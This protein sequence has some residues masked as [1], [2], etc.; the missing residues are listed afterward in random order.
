MST[1]D[2]SAVIFTPFH[3]ISGTLASRDQRLS[4][5]LNDTRESVIRLRNAKVSRQIDSSK[6]IAENSI[7][8][9]SK[10]EI[11]IAFEPGPRESPSTKRLYSFVRK[12][13]HQIF[14]VLDGFEVSGVM[15][16]LGSI[17]TG[18][19]HELITVQK[20]RFL[21]VTQARITFA[22]DERYLITRDAIIVN[23]QRI[24]YIAQADG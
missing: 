7:A 14:M 19:I 21:P 1:L 11:V 2:Y 23:V 24:D 5:L 12:R 18:D 6:I 9:I 22:N 20:D 10:D 8:I 3:S 16:T 17:D 15:H 13:Q 4:D